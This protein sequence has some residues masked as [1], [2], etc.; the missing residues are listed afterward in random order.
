MESI[1]RASLIIIILLTG[2]APQ[3]AATPL[4]APILTHTPFPS[5][6]PEPTQTAIPTPV[7]VIRVDTLGLSLCPR[8]VHANV[9]DT[10][11][12]QIIYADSDNLLGRWSEDTQQA[13]PI[14]LP[15]GAFTA[16][17][18]IDER[19]IIYRH[20][21]GESFNELLVENPNE[22][23]LSHT[24]KSEL[25]VVDP[26]GQ[27][28]RK[29]ATI[30]F[31]EIKRRH[32]RAEYATL[33]Y[34]W[35][36]HADKIYFSVEINGPRLGS[37]PPTYD[38]F[39]LVDIHSGKPIP[40]VK[41]GKASNVAI[42]P[43]GSQAAV[44]IADTL[45]LINIENGDL[46]YT[47]ASR[48]RNDLNGI[49]FRNLA[50]SPDS[51]HVIGFSDE[52][53]VSVNTKDGES[54]SIPLEYTILR[55]SVPATPKFTWLNN[56][57]IAVPVTNLPEGV[58]EIIEPGDY[59]RGPDVNFTV[60]RVNL[61]DA[62]AEP[63]Q[64]FKGFGPS[65]RFSPDGALI[66]FDGRGQYGASQNGKFVALQKTGNML[67]GPPPDLVLADL[68]TGKILAVMNLTVFLGWSPNSR[69]YIYSQ[70]VDLKLGLFPVLLYLGR[71]GK[72][73]LLVR[74]VEQPLDYRWVDE[75]RFVI[76]DGCE[77]LDVKFSP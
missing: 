70:P 6:T 7:P 20:D 11:V 18:L 59:P 44:L 31:D 10:G 56:S 45:R 57:T 65:A 33:D 1:A 54:Q 53:I 69:S 52:G 13:V 8:I 75:E 67:A 4:P 35:I 51:N 21:F 55:G 41:S 39:A 60:W 77:I 3:S 34:G 74:R 58:R 2:C 5:T 68:N 50:Y 15:S 37:L 17:L 43:D 40:L 47:I 26:D 23:Y 49:A 71:A 19:G 46:Q 30:S 28:E 24:E 32:P 72:D 66:V 16:S 42:A 36:P 64:T 25:W 76:K 22:R 62:I 61:L 14:P 63:V 29:L 27:N 48:I 12:L 73:P 9:S 38:T